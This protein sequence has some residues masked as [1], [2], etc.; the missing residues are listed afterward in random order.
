MNDRGCPHKHVARI[1]SHE[2]LV[3]AD[4][5]GAPVASV[6]VCNR[7]GCCDDARLWVRS[8]TGRNVTHYIPFAHED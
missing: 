3:A 2:D 4:E 1:S 5:E 7:R 6:D 8:V